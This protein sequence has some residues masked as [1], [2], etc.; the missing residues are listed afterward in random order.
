MATIGI[1]IPCYKPHW[2]ILPGLL[3]NIQESSRLPD[4]V[5]VS[6]SSW[7]ENG[8]RILEDYPFPILVLFT[9]EIQNAA[10]NRNCAAKHLDTDL[11]SFMDADDRMHPRRLEIVANTME[12]NPTVDALYHSYVRRSDY[13]YTFT[14]EDAASCL[15][16]IEEHP[17]AWS[18]CRV[19]ELDIHHAHVTIRK[20]VFQRQKFVE[21]AWAFRIEDGIFAKQLVQR[22]FVCRFVPFRLSLYNPNPNPPQNPI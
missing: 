9:T 4:K 8:E 2:E 14:E 7:H 20:Q 17:N 19:V 5:V 22:G 3:K 11:I 16:S 15:L 10:Q 12:A 21:E 1:A 18:N 6:C 13:E